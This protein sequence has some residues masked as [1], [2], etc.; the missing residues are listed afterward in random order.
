M[1]LSARTEHVDFR[2]LVAIETVD[3]TRHGVAPAVISTAVCVAALGTSTALA[4]WL[5]VP[6]RQPGRWLS[7]QEHPSPRSERLVLDLAYVIERARQ[8]WARDEALQ[9]WLSGCDALLEGERPLDVV[10]AGGVSSVI[11]AIGAHLA[12]SY[13]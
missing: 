5:G 9:A 10:G 7:C 2:G 1:R 12:G 3:G 4:V 13:A 11:E 6:S 8:V